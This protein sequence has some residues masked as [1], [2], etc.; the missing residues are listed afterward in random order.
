MIDALTFPR[1]RLRRTGPPSSAAALLEGQ[2]GL[3]TPPR[4]RVISFGITAALN[5]RTSVAFGPFVGPVL[6]RGIHWAWDSAIDPNS[7]SLEVG[8]ANVNVVE[9]SVALATVRPYT[10]LT[11]RRDRQN[12]GNAAAGEGFVNWTSP[13][14][15]VMWQKQ[16]H[17]IVTEDHPY[18]ILA[19]VNSSVVAASRVMGDL[20]L[21]EA[22]NLDT[23]SRFSG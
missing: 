18:I 15:L 17:L 10:L 11:E 5:S 9:T 7:R 13:N 21:L 6:I 14:T 3:A 8:W 20:T 2:G 1:P 19:I 22:V 4:G 12:V 16:I 23:L